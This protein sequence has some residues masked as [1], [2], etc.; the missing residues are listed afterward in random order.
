MNVVIAM[1]GQQALAEVTVVVDTAAA[2]TAAAAEHMAKRGGHCYKFLSQ[3]IP[4][5]AAL[6][7]K[8]GRKRRRMKLERRVSRGDET[9]HGT[10]VGYELQLMS[11]AIGRWSEWLFTQARS[12]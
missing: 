5:Q 4:S 3:A 7:R 8:R 6:V 10:Y 2:A 1:A 9:G 12:E 11:M